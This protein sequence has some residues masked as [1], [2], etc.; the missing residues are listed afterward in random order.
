[1]RI[2]FEEDTTNEVAL[3]IPM[4]VLLL[5]DLGEKLGQMRSSVLDSVDLLANQELELVSGALLRVDP[6]GA[7]GNVAGNKVFLVLLSLESV[8][9]GVAQ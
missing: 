7:V 8:C 2:E 6:F 9:V 3:A 4:L 5:R 1:L